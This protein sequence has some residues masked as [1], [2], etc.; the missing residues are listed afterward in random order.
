MLKY[1][2]V[3]LLLVKKNIFLAWF[4][5]ILSMK[6]RILWSINLCRMRGGYQ[7]TPSW[8]PRRPLQ[9]FLAISEIY[10]YFYTSLFLFPKLKMIN[11]ARYRRKLIKFGKQTLHYWWWIW[12]SEV[13]LVSVEIQLCLNVARGFWGVKIV[14]K[15]SV[16]W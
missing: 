6:T 5:V 16:D 14:K 11:S 13:Q 8:V 3:S 2:P 12:Y 10:Y 4:S 15:S 1:L 7:K 9:P